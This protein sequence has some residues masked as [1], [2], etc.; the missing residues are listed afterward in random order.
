MT[1]KR[2]SLARAMRALVVRSA[3]APLGSLSTVALGLRNGRRLSCIHE[4]ASAMRPKAMAKT[5]LST[6]KWLSSAALAAAIAALAAPGAA[7][8]DDDDAI[9]AAPAFKL[10]TTVPVPGL[11]NFDSSTIDP[12]TG[13]DYVSNRTN[14]ALE[15]IDTQRNV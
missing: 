9:R 1:R 6:P 7:R 3:T 14:N 13:L 11:K 4:E 8:A 15:V 10:L 12:S 2:A 5:L